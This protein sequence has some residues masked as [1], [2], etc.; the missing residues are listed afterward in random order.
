MADNPN[1]HIK[2]EKRFH[3]LSN[4]ILEY[5]NSELPWI[6]F[7]K[8]IVTLLLEFSKSESIVLWLPK[9]NLK[10][11]FKEIKCSSKSFSL[12]VINKSNE[13]KIAGLEADEP[14]WTFYQMVS[15]GK[16]DVSL[17]GARETGSI[18]IKDS[19]KTSGYDARIL[20]Y[21]D[22]L[23]TID[24]RKYRTLLFI[25][26][27]IGYT[28]I[29]VLQLLSPEVDFLTEDE[30][31]YY[32]DS[33]QTLGLVIIN[34][35]AQTALRE[36]V[37]EL[38]CLYGISQAVDK[39]GHSLEDILVDTVNLLPAAWQYPQT[40]QARIII[41]GTSYT[42]PGYKEGLHC[43]KADI[44]VNGKLRGRIE[45]W[46]TAE[47]F[48]LDEGPFLIEERNLINTIAK[49]LALIIERKEA[50][51]DRIKL[52]GQ[53]RH[54]DRLATVGQ[55]TAGVA[56]EL[57]E[58][59]GNILGFSQLVM[60]CPDLPHQTKSD[61][62]K[63]I[64][65][66]LYSREVIKKLMLF[67]RQAPAKMLKIDL[68]Q[69]VEDGLYFLESRCN[70]EGIE[71]R[72]SLTPDLPKI[73]ADSAQI[74]QVL[75][76]LVVNAIHAMPD[77]GSLIVQTLK[78]DNHLS[79]IVK[80]TGIGMDEELLKQIFI[81]FFTTKDVGEGT[82]LGLAVVHGI[83]TAHGGTVQVQSEVG[84]GTRFDITFPLAEYMFN[85]EI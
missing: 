68:N 83:V 28:N 8:E 49:E 78:S 65:A 66:S 19:K 13:K 41:D 2:M 33:A 73:T 15:S 4:H 69:V 18:W 37:K 64:T 32:E 82:G 40:T 46:Y 22:R 53:L 36:R 52:E 62:E 23:D 61:I 85:E 56:H 3:S 54:A 70:K 6:E 81:P 74:Q 12:R 27:K 55:L 14:S 35:R 9:D 44:A 63:I 79:L 60:K 17:K 59:L 11:R 20:Q 38:T 31:K 43:Q 57:N 21:L 71:V 34:Q 25:P 16:D 75:V 10:N 72:R 77:G 84:K 45:V 1:L 29:G 24:N 47:K 7:L 50:E 67:T 39:H 42:T 76:N 80:D 5:A 51:R 26:I 58:P 48:T 30:V